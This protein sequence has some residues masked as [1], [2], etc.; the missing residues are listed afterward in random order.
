[1]RKLGGQLG[2]EAMSLYNHVANKDDILDGIVELVV[3]EF[4]APS[5]EAPWQVALRDTARSA[6]KVLLRHPWAAALV[7]SRVTPSHVRFRYSEAVIGT[8][9]QA[10]FSIEQ[11][12]RAQ[13]TINA[14]VHGFTLQEV[15]WPFAPAEQHSVA[16]SLQP[17]VDSDEHPYLTEMIGWIMQTRFP[18][19]HRR[20]A[21]AYESEFE[22][23]LD[24]V[25]DGLAKLL[26]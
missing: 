4:A 21:V 6:R 22:F 9:R 7:E 24:L 2:V 5:D 10:G 25:L 17:H 14:Y 3:S 23:G 11:A 18:S 16:T 19:A 26:P 13:L 15:N 20:D 8:L 1:M 12:Y